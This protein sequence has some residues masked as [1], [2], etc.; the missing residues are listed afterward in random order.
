MRCLKI[1]CR[2]SLGTSDVIDDV[3]DITGLANGSSVGAIDEHTIFAR[4][5]GDYSFMEPT[6]KK[7]FG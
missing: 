3:R 2:D 4:D 7:Q 6:K 5:K 1:V